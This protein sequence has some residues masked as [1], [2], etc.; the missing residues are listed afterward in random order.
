MR[1][2]LILTLLQEHWLYDKQLR[3]IVSLTVLTPLFGLKGPFG[4][5]VVLLEQDLTTEIVPTEKPRILCYL[6]FVR[7]PSNT[8][9]DTGN[10]EIYDGY[11]NVL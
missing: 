9:H 5:C 7:M 2:S 6:L 11:T 1:K 8:T 3:I 10:I 4:E